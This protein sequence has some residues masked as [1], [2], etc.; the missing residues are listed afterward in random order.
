[1][2]KKS[3]LDQAKQAFNPQS[4]GARLTSAALAPMGQIPNALHEAISIFQKSKGKI[5]TEQN[6]AQKGAHPIANLRD[7][8]LLLSD[9]SVQQTPESQK[10]N[11]L[12]KNVLAQNTFNPQAQAYL[13]NIRMV[14]GTP[15]SAAG[16]YTKHGLNG[17]PE[18]AIDRELLNEPDPQ[19]RL[20]DNAS[21][22]PMWVARNKTF[23]TE[24]L[25][26]EFLHALDENI[27]A[28]KEMD[29]VDKTKD[30]SGN[31]FGFLADMKSSS[32]KSLLREMEEFLNS[33]PKDSHVR[34]VESF[35]QYGAPRGSKVLMSPMGKRY[36]NVFVPISKQIRYNPVYPTRDTYNR[37]ISKIKGDDDF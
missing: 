37:L 18:I 32:P 6:R 26:H 31:S 11:I 13:Q 36:K 29:Y 7:G 10:L 28:E 2:K 17:Q 27:N 20:P 34:D 23:P 16:T 30:K 15:E 5:L 4:L 25:T 21:Q 24:V 35:A 1:M 12:R 8:S 3:A 22:N 19:R 9:G 33:Y 14:Y